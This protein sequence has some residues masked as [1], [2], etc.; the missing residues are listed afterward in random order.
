MVTKVLFIAAALVAIVPDPLLAK[1]RSPDAAEV[2]R[3]F[4]R[5][6]RK[7]SASDYDRDRMRRT[8]TS[9]IGLH[10]TK[11]QV[12]ERLIVMIFYQRTARFRFKSYEQCYERIAEFV[13]SGSFQRTI[14]QFSDLHANQARQSIWEMTDGKLVM[15]IVATPSNDLVLTLFSTE[16][17]ALALRAIRYMLLPRT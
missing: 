5:F 11:E 1:N 8:I 4:E 3:A 9:N 10:S 17:R 6:H 7:S 14:Y 2:L 12:S 13:A 15:R 16:D